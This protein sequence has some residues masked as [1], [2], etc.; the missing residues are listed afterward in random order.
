MATSGTV[1]TTVFETR[2][3]IDRAFGRAKMPPQAI[4]GELV[5]IAKQNLYLLLSHLANLGAPLWCVEKLIIPAYQGQA[6]ITLPVGTVDVMNANFRLLQQITGT[7]TLLPQTYTV[8]LGSATQITTVGIQPA[9]NQT[10]NLSFET[11]PDNVTWTTIINVGSVSYVAGQWYWYDLDGTIP[12]QYFRARETAV[13]AGIINFTQ[14][15]TGNTP[16]AI[17]MARMNQD[18]YTSLP[19]KTSAG[20]PLQYWLSQVLPQKIMYTW[21]VCDSINSVG[22]FIVWRHRQIQD[23]GTSLQTIE[24]PQEWFDTVVWGL[25]F[26]MAQE[27]PEIDDARVANIEGRYKSSLMESQD[28]N[29]D[30]SPT[31]FAPAIAQ[32]TM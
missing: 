25:A 14:L 3:I 15:F 21:P 24:V 12:T 19:N 22:Q 8:N 18:D 32:Y 17:P 30:N 6:K 23:V 27:I 28:Q 31:F 5:D 13:P 4:T 7:N 11:S 2:K 9:V 29:R 10:L 20:K 26:R 1:S 16:S